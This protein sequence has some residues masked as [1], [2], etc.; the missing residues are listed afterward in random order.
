M[1]CSSQRNLRPVPLLEAA[2]EDTL[3]AIGMLAAAED[4]IVAR[5]VDIVGPALYTGTK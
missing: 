2:T 1:R 3:Q 4:T 5:N